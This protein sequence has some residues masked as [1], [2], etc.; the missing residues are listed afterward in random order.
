MQGGED[1]DLETLLQECGNQVDRP[2][3]TLRR[4]TTLTEG[5]SK[6]AQPSPREEGQMAFT[7][8]AL[9]R[10]NEKLM[11]VLSKQQELSR[12]TTEEGGTKRKTKEEISYHPQ[13]PLMF[14]EE[15]YKIHDDSHDHIDTV[16]R[17]KLRPIN[18]CPSTYWKK[19]AFRQVE[20]PIMGSAIYLEYIL[21]GNMNES[22]ICKSHDRCAFIEIKNFLSKN[23][24]VARENK[25]KIKVY[26]VGNDEF[27]MGVQTHWEQASTVWEVMDAGLNFLAVEWMIRNYSFTALAMIRCLHEC[28]CETVT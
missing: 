24:G 25:K 18:V 1:E 20:R 14:D 13:D 4:E 26:E 22:V 7:V 11:E 27:G 10:Q 3:I 16:L 12:G 21:P 9:L 28:R 23:S 5:Q 6:E 2:Q 8:S 17:Q 15:A 19:G